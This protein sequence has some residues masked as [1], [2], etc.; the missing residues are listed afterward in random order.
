MQP[1]EE[2]ERIVASDAGSLVVEAG[3]GAAKTTTLGLYASARPRSRILYLAFNKSIQLEAAARMPRNV[4]CRTTHSI[5]WRK[6]AELFGGEASQRVGKTYASSVART[7]RCGPLVATAALQ[8]IQNWCG[9]LSSQIDASHVPTDIAE[10]LAD[11]GSVVEIARATWAR[12]CRPDG[13]E[14]RLPHD[15]YLKLFQM[16]EP[17]LRGQDLVAVDEAQDLNM[18]TYDIVRR[19]CGGLVLVGDSAQQIFAFRGS[20]N[21]LRIHEADR[22]L[23]LTRS[24]RFGES[25]A[26]MANALLDHFKLDNALHIV[27]AGRVPTRLTVDTQRSFAVL[28]RTNAVVF[29]EAISFL[30]TNRRYHFVGGPEGYRMEKLLDAYYLWAGSG[31][32]V[33]DPYLRSFGSFEDLQQLADD[34]ADPELRHLVRVVEDYG[35][36]V[37]ALVDQIKS[38]H[39]ALDRASWSDFEGVFFSTAHKAKGLEF[40]QVWLAD[41]FMRFFED[42]KELTAEEVEQADVNLLYV[43]LTRAKESIRLSAGFDEWLTY[44]RLR[45]R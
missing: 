2:Q 5:A 12:M 8:A 32:Q 44:R 35:G 34:A 17:M 14:L 9:S 15:G 30:S 31:G 22:R 33:R 41:D 40:D 37:P 45:P 13:G 21:A 3:A 24:F 4:N 6:A 28:A 38:R 19:Q 23:Q 20:A 10:R 25:L 1:T 7:F 29:E 36:R 11:P 18:C 43:A 26:Q 39:V 42:G 16:E 27:G